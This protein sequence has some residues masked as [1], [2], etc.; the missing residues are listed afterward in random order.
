MGH[1]PKGIVH[2]DSKSANIFVTERGYA[3]IL[4]CLAKMKKISDSTL[5]FKPLEEVSRG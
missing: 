3:K 1:P 5:R 4:D 2:R